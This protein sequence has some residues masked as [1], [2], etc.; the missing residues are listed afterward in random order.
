M[1][2]TLP[3]IKTTNRAHYSPNRPMRVEEDL[4]CY[5]E[6]RFESIKKSDE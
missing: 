1:T 3:M 5:Y 4:M 2:E 6:K